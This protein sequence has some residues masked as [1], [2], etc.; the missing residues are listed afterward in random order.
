MDFDIGAGE[1][2]DL[3]PVLRLNERLDML[4]MPAA[5]LRGYGVFV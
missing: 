1:S 5:L 2:L 3:A 4:H